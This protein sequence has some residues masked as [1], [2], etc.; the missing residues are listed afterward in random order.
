LIRVKGKGKMKT[1]W[2]MGKKSSIVQQGN[3]WDWLIS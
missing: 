2:L 3:L 1:Y